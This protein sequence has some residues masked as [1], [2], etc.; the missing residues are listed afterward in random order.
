[1]AKLVSKVYGDALFEAAM[2]KQMLDTVYEE[3]SALQVI[4]QENPDLV[5]TLNHPKI[6]KEEKISILENIFS[7]KV[8]DELMGFLTIIVEKGRQN[9][10]SAIFQY[11]IGRVKEYK[12]IGT[13]YIT[14]AVELKETQKAQIKERLLATTSYVEFEMIYSVDSALIGGLVI[15]IGDRV[16]DSSIKTQLYELKKN[17][18]KL[19]LA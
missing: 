17:L 2:E 3:V 7:G 15:R 13:A 12:K 6:V 5:R 18:S 9:D 14:S 16:V 1:M 11:F 4:F 19:Q 10:I 8:S